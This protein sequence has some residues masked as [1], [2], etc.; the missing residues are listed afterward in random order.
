MKGFMAQADVASGISTPASTASPFRHDLLDLLKHGCRW[1]RG[2]RSPYL[3]WFDYRSRC[4]VAAPG[5]RHMRC[6]PQV[7]HSR[8]KSAV[9]KPLSPTTVVLVKCS[10][11]EEL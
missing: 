1:K 6:H 5:L 9:S 8:I 10:F 11:R 2:L 7:R 4:G 3:A